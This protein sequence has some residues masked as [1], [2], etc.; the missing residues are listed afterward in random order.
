M[1]CGLEMLWFIY[2]IYEAQSREFLN[3]FISDM[4]I[5]SNCMEIFVLY[6]FATR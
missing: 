1:N 3:K 6:Y 2:T 4:W 5:I